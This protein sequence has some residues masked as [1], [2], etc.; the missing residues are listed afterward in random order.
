[1]Y[2]PK[3]ASPVSQNLLLRLIADHILGCSNLHSGSAKPKASAFLLYF[4]QIYLK[5]TQ[6]KLIDL[7]EETD[8]GDFL[9]TLMAVV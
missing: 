1:M 2:C 3:V 8:E 4:S 7:D 5:L 9:V 6:E